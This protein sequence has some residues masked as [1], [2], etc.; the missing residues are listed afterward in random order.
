MGPGN[1]RA[2]FFVPKFFLPKS[3]PLSSGTQFS[4]L[5]RGRRARRLPRPLSSGSQLSHLP[6]GRRVRRLPPPQASRCSQPPENPQHW[7]QGSHHVDDHPL[8]PQHWGQGSHHVADHPLVPPAT[9]SSVLGSAVASARW[10]SGTILSSVHASAVP[11]LGAGGALPSLAS[12][13]HS[14]G[15]S[16]R[17]HHRSHRSAAPLV[18]RRQTAI[19]HSPQSHSSSLLLLSFATTTTTVVVTACRACI[20]LS[21]HGPGDSVRSP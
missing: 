13:L 8:G 20:N 14:L 5:R 1:S 11:S 16:K 10:G 21:R 3:G 9:S 12:A 2:F 6:R 18:H 17:H 7:G 15:S 19:L 4:H